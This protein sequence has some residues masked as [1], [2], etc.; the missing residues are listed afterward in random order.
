MTKPSSLFATLAAALIALPHANSAE[1]PQSAIE[2]SGVFPRLAMV[3][4]HSPR[5][6]AGTGALMPW[7]D[8]LWIVT[9]VAHMEESG[10]GTGL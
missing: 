9:Y 7:A 2:V 10:S 1:A 3:A 8:R 6:E 4:D 5:T